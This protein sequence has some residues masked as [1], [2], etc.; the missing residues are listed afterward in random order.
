MVLYTTDW[1]Y[2]IVFCL[3]I[4]LFCL[5]LMCL[6]MHRFKTFILFWGLW[7]IRNNLSNS[8]PPPPPTKTKKNEA[9]NP[10]FIHLLCTVLLSTQRGVFTKEILTARTTQKVET[11]HQFTC[12]RFEENC[13]RRSSEIQGTAIG[14]SLRAWT[15]HACGCSAKQFRSCVRLEVA[16]LGCPS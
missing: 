3:F 8:P 5:R 2:V 6:H 11:Y 4:F 1:F 15:V 16:V 12:P 9:I 14:K 7:P 10:P 13:N